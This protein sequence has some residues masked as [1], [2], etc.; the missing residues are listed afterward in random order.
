M[1]LAG[2]EEWTFTPS[3]HAVLSRLLEGSP[4]PLG[5]LAETSGLTVGQ[6]AGLVTELVNANVAA[7]S[8][9]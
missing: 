8:E 6:V 7:V 1:L 4:V 5:H 2:G 3:A 9:P